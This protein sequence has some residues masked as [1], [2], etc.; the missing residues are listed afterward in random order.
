MASS[1]KMNKLI[2]ATYNYKWWANNMNG[3]WIFLS[4]QS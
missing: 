3:E 1:E 2:L 4:K